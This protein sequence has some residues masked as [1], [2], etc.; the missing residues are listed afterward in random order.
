MAATLFA[1]AGWG[2]PLTIYTLDQQDAAQWS[3]ALGQTFVAPCDGSLIE[4]DFGA[5]WQAPPRFQLTCSVREGGPWGLPVGRPCT[6]QIDLNKDNRIAARWEPG[7][8]PL[9]FGRL[10]FL[11]MW[12]SSGYALR[13][14]ED[15]YAGGCAFFGDSRFMLSRPQFDLLG[16]MVMDVRP[17]DVQI[18]AL[19]TRDGRT[20]IEVVNRG[21][22]DA[23]IVAAGAGPAPEGPQPDAPAVGAVVPGGGTTALE[24][25]GG[26]GAPVAGGGAAGWV[27]AFGS[28]HNLIP[29]AGFE[30]ARS[31]WRI[32]PDPLPA[33]ITCGV[34]QQDSACGQASLRQ[35]MRGAVAGGEVLATSAEIAIEPRGEYLVGGLYR[36]T[37]DEHAA[38]SLVV[39]E[40]GEVAEEGREHR[41]AL[42]PADRWTPFA[43][44]VT[45]GRKTTQLDIGLSLRATADGAT[46]EVLWDALYLIPA[47]ALQ[48]ITGPAEPPA[49]LVPPAA[50][51]TAPALLAFAR[52]AIEERDYNQADAALRRLLAEYPR[53]RDALAAREELA[54]LA[55][56]R[57]ATEEAVDRFAA[58]IADAPTSAEAASAAMALLRYASPE[59]VTAAWRAW[60]A[61]V[62]RLGPDERGAAWHHRALVLAS[63]GRTEECAEALARCMLAN[64]ESTLVV[65]AAECLVRACETEAAD[66]LFARLAPN[67]AE[68]RAW[69][70]FQR[71]IHQKA[72]GN[73][74]GALATLRELTAHAG[75]LSV[76]PIAN[77]QLRAAALEIGKIRES[78]GDY[79]G[80]SPILESGMRAAMPRD[81]VDRALVKAFNLLEAECVYEFAGTLAYGAPC[82]RERLEL[83]SKA[84]L[85]HLE[86]HHGRGA[87]S[88]LYGAWHRCEGKAA[89]DAFQKRVQQMRKGGAK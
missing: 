30:L 19:T 33:E 88:M 61:A 45:L 58:L 32:D 29:N 85:H 40:V 53:G 1:R 8:V 54:W 64:P 16:R 62:A 86:T 87:A 24:V 10:Y 15:G 20:V 68:A 56:R 59:R 71:S 48:V 50:G 75:R 77:Y 36:T 49:P 43:A 55:A 18:R 65:T 2:A 25:V 51:A 31:K 44:K 52:K 60:E 79:R 66:A 5:T 34:S 35:S 73:P 26:D 39:Y 47:S 76:G 78:W 27:L 11:E 74:S 84:A 17:A 6:T 57:G 14:S 80:A 70:Q 37:G 21:D 28:H 38:P 7:D 89:A 3:G 72:G 12:G 63:A 83:A 9:R 13:L 23:H 46:G 82:S 81:D 41:T 22:E 42:A 67:A 4:V 69:A